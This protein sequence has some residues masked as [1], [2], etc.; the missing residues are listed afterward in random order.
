M[1][2]KMNNNTHHP[3]RMTSVPG[4]LPGSPVARKFTTSVTDP[5]QRLRSPLEQPT[6]FKYFPNLK[7]EQRRLILA[8]TLIC[9][10]ILILGGCMAWWLK[11]NT[12]PA[13]TIYR[14]GKPQ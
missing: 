3:N 4:S 11:A 8:G 13:V 10:S 5:P 6:A 12:L 1:R 14:V 9:C 2:F 7:Y